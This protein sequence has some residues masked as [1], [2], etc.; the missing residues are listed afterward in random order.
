MAKDK[1]GISESFGATIIKGG[2]KK[3]SLRLILVDEEGRDLAERE[4]KQVELEPSGAEAALA[5]YAKE[6]GF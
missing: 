6:F 2:A 1:L 3:C 5:Q 4:L